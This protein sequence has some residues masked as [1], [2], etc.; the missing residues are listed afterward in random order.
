MQKS[1]KCSIL[2]ATHTAHNHYMVLLRY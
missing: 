2:K 1:K